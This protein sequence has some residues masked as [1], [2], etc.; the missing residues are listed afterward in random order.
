MLL[1]MLLDRVG[2]ASD[3]IR[4]GVHAIFCDPLYKTCQILD[5]RGLQYEGLSLRHMRVLLEAVSV[6]MD[7]G[8]QDQNFCSLWQDKTW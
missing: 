6:V 7:L 1:H 5:S 8:A 2:Q 3:K 4:E